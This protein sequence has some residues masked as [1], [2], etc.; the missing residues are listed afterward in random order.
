M[1]LIK[2]TALLV[3]VNAWMLI[4]LPR[5]ASEGLPSRG[6]V[7]VEGTINGFRFQAPLEPDGRGGH[8]FKVDQELAAGAAVGVGGTVTV[9][10]TPLREWPEPSVPEDLEAHLTADLRAKTL[11]QDITTRARWDWIRWI[12]STKNPKT[13]KLRLEKTIAKLTSGERTPCCFHRSICSE[14]AV[15][16]NGVLLD[17]ETSPL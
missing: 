14:P 7:M 6:M 2:F 4:R 17:A 16:Q 15:S 8:W 13:R 9:E 11:W 10:I 3:N 12:R 1:V 5:S